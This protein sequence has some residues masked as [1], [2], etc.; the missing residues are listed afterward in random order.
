MGREYMYDVLVVGAGQAGLAMGYYLKKK[1]LSFLI[2][3]QSSEVGE[4]W[5]NRYD[6]LTLFTPR[7]YSNLPGMILKGEQGGYPKK[8]EI[9]AYLKSYAKTFS[10]PIKLNTLI[11]SLD[12][13]DAAFELT[14]NK[15]KYRARNIV[16]ATGPFQH[17]NIPGFSKNLSSNIFQLHSSEYKN[18]S[19]LKEGTTLVVGGGNSGAQIA[20][21][22]AE[23][24]TVYLSVGH[25]L[26]FLPQD[27]GNRS[28]FWWFDKL[29]FLKANVNSNFGR[30]LKNRPD[31][32]FGLELKEK[33][34]LA[35]VKV[36]PKV[37][38][39]KGSR[40]EFEDGGLLEVNNIIWSTGFKPDYTW[41]KVPF[42]FD[43]NGLPIHDRGITSKKGLYFLGM[44][45][46]YRRGSA[47]LQG[48][49]FDANHL[50]DNLNI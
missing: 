24:R 10:L 35:K 47:I 20:T 38:S 40:V 1:N 18:P 17:P 33:I 31:P 27:I 29:G 3:D 22:I 34:K 9:S 37:V 50:A 26:R 42:I 8:D 21:E 30:Y 4:S 11:E 2:L 36:K 45:W 28:I 49:G 15:G 46:Q 41:I 39:V 19:Q 6:S 44:P 25:R 48:I 12:E 16:V 14:T 5:K 43:H 23:E 7:T 13:I 32:I